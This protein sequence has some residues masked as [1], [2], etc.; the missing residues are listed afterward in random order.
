MP[1]YEYAC[2]D[3]G[4]HEDIPRPV[5]FR[6]FSAEC[7]ECGG[8]MVRCMSAPRIHADSYDKPIH[9]DA[10]AIHPDQVAEHQ[11]LYPDV[12]LDSQCRPILSKFSQHEKYINARGVYKAPSLRS[13]RRGKRI[14]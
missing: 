4:I 2:E 10:L 3:C 11:K 1:I 7:K 12:P 8:S 14:A 9:S 6:D 5:E 13:K